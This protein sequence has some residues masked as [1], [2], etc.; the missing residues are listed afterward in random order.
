MRVDGF[1][2]CFIF[3]VLNSECLVFRKRLVIIFEWISDEIG[4]KINLEELLFRR[5]YEYNLVR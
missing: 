1:Y 5:G 2:D 3:S 4:I